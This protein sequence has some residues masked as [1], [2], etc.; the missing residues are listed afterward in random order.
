MEQTRTTQGRCQKLCQAIKISS[1]LLDSFRAR[2]PAKARPKGYGSAALA[3]VVREGNEPLVRLLLSYGADTNQIIQDRGDRS[4]SPFGTA[5]ATVQPNRSNIIEPFLVAGCDPNKV[6]SQTH[7]VEF[8]KTVMRGLTA[9]MAAITTR[10]CQLI[11]LLVKRGA[12]VNLPAKGRIKRTPLQMAVEVGDRNICEFLLN[13]GAKVNTSAASS[14]GRTALQFAAIGGK[15]SIAY[16]L[17]NHGAEVDAPAAKVDGYTALEGAAAHGRLNI[18]QVL[19]NAGACS[20]GKDE[21]QLRRVAALAKDI[22]NFPI[23]DLLE[24]TMSEQKRF[25]EEEEYVKDVGMALDE[26]AMASDLDAFLNYPDQ[27]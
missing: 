5:I 10:D 21:G 9:F 6:V 8:Y 4:E 14:G 1:R 20:G 15:E 19:L 3:Q 23:V 13:L 22:G 18:V 17:L 24:A 7:T 27:E 16:L 2:Y 11:E 12:D 26:D 25:V